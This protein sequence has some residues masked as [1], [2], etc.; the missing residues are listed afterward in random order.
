VAALIKTGSRPEIHLVEGCVSWGNVDS[1]EVYWISEYNKNGNKT[2][3]VNLM[4]YSDKVFIKPN[5]A[6]KLKPIN[7]SCR[8]KMAL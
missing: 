6:A 8:Q 5:K 4:G 7:L 3:N 2:Y 1:R